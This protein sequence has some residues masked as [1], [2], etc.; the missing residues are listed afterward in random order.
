MVIAIKAAVRVQLLTTPVASLMR[1]V[2]GA[3]AARGVTASRTSRVSQT[4]TESKPR[5]SAYCTSSICSESDGRSQKN[6]PYSIHV[7]SLG[8]PLL[9][10]FDIW[11]GDNAMKMA[12]GSTLP[13]ERRKQAVKFGE[14][15]C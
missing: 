5:C 7:D 2:I 11:T 3:K 13:G 14:G 8:T 9:I 10:T 6:Q 4:H 12:L 1:W 15:S